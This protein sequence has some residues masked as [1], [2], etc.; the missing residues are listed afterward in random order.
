MANGN[1]GGSEGGL[2]LSGNVMCYQ[3]PE[4]LT[5]EKH[6]NLGIKPVE[7]PFEFLKEVATVPLTVDEFGMAATAYPV[8]FTGT[9]KA[10]V[11]VMGV[12]QGHNL[13]VTDQ[14]M[15]EPDFYVPTFAR[16][17]PFAFANHEEQDAFVLCVD[18]KAPMVTDLPTVPFFENGELSP[19]T[20]DAMEFCKQ[21]EVQRQ[22]TVE[23]SKMLD[24]KGLFEQ[25]TVTFQPRDNDGKEVGEAQLIAEY[26]AI[27]EEKLNNLSSESFQEVRTKGGVGAVYAHLI[28][29]VNWKRI[30]DRAL[31]DQEAEPGGQT[32]QL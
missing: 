23:F 22:A 27:S 1:T 26:W 16:R 29:L 7:K 19:Y 32:P 6:A 8:I 20:K 13:F 14:G 12:R 17:Y 11:A 5:I 24:Q 2:T 30:V 21:F 10:P 25:K 28:S 15:T 9:A 3:Q 31:K 18:R 4:V